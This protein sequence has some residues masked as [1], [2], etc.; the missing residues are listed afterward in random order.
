MA[1]GGAMTYAARHGYA[2]APYSYVE[3][4]Y[5]IRR[6]PSLRYSLLFKVSNLVDGEIKMLKI[7]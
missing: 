3:Y 5:S 1:K 4:Y 6:I 7:D 2:Y